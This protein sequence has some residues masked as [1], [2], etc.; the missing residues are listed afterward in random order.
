MLVVEPQINKVLCSFWSPLW[1]HMSNSSKGN[2]I[3]SIEV[4]NK[5]WYLIA[6]H[7]WS[8][9][10]SLL[11]WEVEIFDPLLGAVGWDGSIS[12][13]GVEGHSD[14]VVSQDWVYPGWCFLLEMIFSV[15]FVVTHCPCWSTIVDIKIC[16]GLS[17]VQPGFKTDGSCNCLILVAVF[18]PWGVLSSGHTFVDGTVFS[19]L[20]LYF[21]RLSV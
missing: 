14:T 17:F 6:C 16:S 8:P 18:G 11:L 3:K 13:S 15:N 2:E 7:P 20:T 21:S 5:S 10:T 9:V 4:F 12:V 19:H 1:C